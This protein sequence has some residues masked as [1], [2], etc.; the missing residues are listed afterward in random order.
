MARW[1]VFDVDGTLIPGT[2]MEKMFLGFLLKKG[3]L[4]LRN[5]V[6]FVFNGVVSVLSYGMEEGLA[7]NKAYIRGLAAPAVEEAAE[8]CFRER[9]LP[10]FSRTGLDKLESLR[11]QRHKI[12]IISGSP[13]F[14]ARRLEPGLRPDHIISA[15]METGGGFFTGK[16]TG[17]HPYGE[18]KR[19]I[20][21][22]L[23]AHLALDF[24]KSTVFANH[25]SDINHMELFGTAVAVNPTPPLREEAVRRG[26][27]VVTWR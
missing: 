25:H 6:N 19:Q 5:V 21:E 20:L 26:W 16:M 8:T 9:I 15:E 7:V 22:G 2:S 24:G 27:D 18:R 14:L 11:T 12:L 3:K 4:P 13:S 17:L 23:R 1:A 10:V